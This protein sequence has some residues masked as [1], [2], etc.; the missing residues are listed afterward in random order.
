[1]GKRM[2]ATHEVLDAGKLFLY[3][4]RFRAR[5]AFVRSWE[6]VVLEVGE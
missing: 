3:A 5:V 6:L 1:M 4:S 2:S